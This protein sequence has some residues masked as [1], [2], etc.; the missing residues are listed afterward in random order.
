MQPFGKAGKRGRAWLQARRERQV[1]RAPCTSDWQ[2]R[3]KRDYRY[4]EREGRRG[5]AA[6]WREGTVNDEQWIILQVQ[7]DFNTC[8]KKM[9]WYE[10]INKPKLDP[11]ILRI[12]GWGEAGGFKFC[13]TLVVWEL[14]EGEYKDLWEMC[15]CIGIS[16]SDTQTEKDERVKRH[17]APRSPLYP[18]P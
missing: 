17:A 4:R 3:V 9:L 11:G 14:D 7:V 2:R 13:W 18:I 16:W 8:Q 1:E 10:A 5:E 6:R 12:S 15:W